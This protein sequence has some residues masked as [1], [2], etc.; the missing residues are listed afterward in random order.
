MW[1][2]RIYTYFDL[3]CAESIFSIMVQYV[4]KLVAPGMCPLFIFFSTPPS[5]KQRTFAVES[6]QKQQQQPKSYKD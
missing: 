2:Q 3:N 1:L 4:Q 5:R 6:E